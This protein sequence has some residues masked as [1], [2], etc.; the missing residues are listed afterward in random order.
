MYVPEF[1]SPEELV[2]PEVFNALG[3]RCLLL[4]DDRLLRQADLL[5]RLLGPLLVNTWK[6]DD[7]DSARKYS[8]FRSCRYAHGA[9]YSQHRFGRALDLI[10]KADYS[11][12]KVEGMRREIIRN[13]RQGTEDVRFIRAIED[14]VNWLHI[15]V[16]CNVP[17]DEVF[18]FKP[19]GGGTY[20]HFGD[21]AGD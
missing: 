19:G 5:R 1:F 17:D 8:G 21:S 6:W 12:E 9:K 18:L 11:P 16:R 4:F 20:L 14:E 2:P 13:I 15:D 7:S 10:P 3:S